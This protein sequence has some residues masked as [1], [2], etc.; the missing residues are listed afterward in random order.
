MGGSS[1]SPGLI[2]K[3]PNDVGHGVSSSP[4]RAY[5]RCDRASVSAWSWVCHKVG[6]RS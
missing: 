2:G 4:V 1:F 6:M 3:L 5:F